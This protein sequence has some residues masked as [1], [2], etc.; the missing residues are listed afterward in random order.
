MKIKSTIARLSLALAAIAVSGCVDPY[1]DDGPSHVSVYRHNPGYYVTTLPSGY[2]TE[3]V[4]GVH[5]YRHHDDF[6]RPRGRGF[7]VVE[8]PHHR[9][10]RDRDRDHSDRTSSWNHRRSFR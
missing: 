9:S 10:E 8:T 5:Y 2:R 7:V 3:I 4:G 1:Y 6:Y